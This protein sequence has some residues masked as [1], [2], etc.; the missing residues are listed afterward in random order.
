[1]IEQ[2]I[3]DKVGVQK[4]GHWRLGCVDKNVGNTGLLPDYVCYARRLQLSVS[5]CVGAIRRRNVNRAYMVAQVSPTASDKVLIYG[6]C[7]S[8]SL[9]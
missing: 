7:R 1:M 8:S 5:A 2:V 4:C 3:D 6:R 9:N